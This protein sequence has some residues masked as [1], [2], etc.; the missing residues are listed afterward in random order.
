MDM[1][2][3]TENPYVSFS[4]EALAGDEHSES[5]IHGYAAV[6]ADANEGI[7]LSF[8]E[9]FLVNQEAY[10]AGILKAR[11]D[12][13]RGRVQLN[14]CIVE[15]ETIESSIEHHDRYE[16]FEV[17]P[18]SVYCP[19]SRTI[20]SLVQS[21]ENPMSFEGFFEDYTFRIARI[22]PYGVEY[23]LDACLRILD[24]Q[25]EK[26]DEGLYNIICVTPFNDKFKTAINK[27][28][29]VL[30]DIYFNETKIVKRT[31]FSTGLHLGLR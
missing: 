26:V 6:I 11:V 19:P 7:E 22:Q 16:L 18:N 23:Q 2:A 15:Q 27:P 30:V 3:T 25:G 4:R 12:L 17:K 5:Y 10:N 9:E 8:K 24:E 31:A 20:E 13:D 29:A 1:N 14:D 28:T 21:L